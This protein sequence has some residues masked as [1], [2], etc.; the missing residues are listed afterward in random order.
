LKF[1][2][3]AIGLAPVN[4]QNRLHSCPN[5]PRTCANRHHP[6]QLWHTEWPAKPPIPAASSVSD[7]SP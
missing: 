7:A 5:R 4:G 1:G 6:S 2:E 3:E